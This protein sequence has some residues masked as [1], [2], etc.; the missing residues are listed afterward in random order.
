MQEEN[1]SHISSTSDHPIPASCRTL[2]DIVGWRALH[3]PDQQAYI[4]LDDGEKEAT[5]ITYAQLEWQAKSIAAQLQHATR[6]GERALLLYPPGLAYIAAFMGCLYAGVVAVPAYPPS[7]IRS[8]GRIQAIAADARA[9]LVLTTGQTIT[10]VARWSESMPELGAMRWLA[11]DEKLEGWYE[12]WQLQALTPETLTFLQYTSGSTGTPKG[13]MVSHGNL[14]HNCALMCERWGHSGAS[15]SVSWLPIF[16]DMGLIAG[17]LQPLYAGFLAVLMAPAA[18]IQRPVRWLQAISSYRGTTSWAPNFAYE[19]CVRRVTENECEQLDLRSWRVAGNGAEP[20]RAET[21][22]QFSRR[23]SVSGF[24]RAAFTPGYGLAEGTLMVASSPVEVAPVLLPLEKS[25]LELHR[26]VVGA[27]GPS[28]IQTFVGCGPGA[29]DQR[30]VIVNPETS[31]PCAPEEIGEI[32]VKGASITQGYWQRPQE[33]Q[34]IFMASLADTE[35]GPFLRTGDLGFLYHGELFITGRLKDIIIIRGRNHYPQD[36]ELTVEKSH[37]LLRPGCGAAFTVEVG[38]EE[39]LVIVQELMRDYHTIDEICQVIRQDVASL[40]EVQIYAIVLIRYGSISKT[41]SGKIQRRACRDA[42]VQ[43]NLQ[44][45]AQDVVM[46]EPLDNQVYKPL[47]S[48]AMLQAF[49]ADRQIALLQAGIQRH[50]EQI[51]HLKYEQIAFDIPMGAYGLDSLRAAELQMRLEDELDISLSFVDLLNGTTI[52]GLATIVLAQVGI[53]DVRTRQTAIIPDAQVPTTYPLSSWQEQLWVLYQLEPHS[54]FYTV[55]LALHMQGELNSMYLQR[56]LDEVVRRHESLRTTFRVTD[57][58]AVQSVHPY[59]VVQL[60]LVDLQGLS[61]GE[62][63]SREVQKKMGEMQQ[64]PFDLTQD[65]LLRVALF[66]LSPDESILL[67]VMHH[68]I[69]DG[70]SVGIFIRE[71]EQC[72]NAM[73]DNKDICLPALPLRYGDYVNWQRKMQQSAS[74]DE[75]RS[76]WKQQLEQVPV[77]DFPTDHPRPSVQRYRGAALRFSV[78]EVLVKRYQE[79]CSQEGVTLFMAFLAVFQLLLTR[80]SRQEECILGTVVANRP[81]LELKNLIG[82]F[83]NTLVIRTSVAKEQSYRQLLQVVR[84]VCLDAY[85]H[86]QFPFSRLVEELR[87]ERGLDRNPLFQ[88]VFNW[89]PDVLEELSFSGIQCVPYEIEEAT[90]RFDLSVEWMQRSTSLTATVIYNTDLFE[91]ATI[92]NLMTHYQVL[93]EACVTCPDDQIASMPLLSTAQY[94]HLVTSQKISDKP[95]G[96]VHELFAA[97][98]ERMPDALALVYG[99]ECLTYAE[100][101]RRS[102]NFATMLRLY[103]IEPGALVG[104]CLHRS[105]ELIVGLLG[106]LKA[107]GVYVPLDPAYPAQRLALMMHEAALQLVITRHGILSALPAIERVVL[108]LDDIEMQQRISLPQENRWSEERGLRMLYVIYTSGSTGQPKGAATYHHSFMALL[109]WFI[110]EF[111]ISSHDRVLLTSSFSFDLTQKNIFAP[112]LV[113]GTLVLH[114][115]QQFE[116]SLLS[117]SL[118]EQA[119]TVLNWTPS[120]FYSVIEHRSASAFP[121]LRSVFLGGEPVSGRRIISWLAEYP[122]EIINTYGPTE[123]TDVVAY[124]RSGIPA[125]LEMENVPIG[126]AIGGTRLLVLDEMQRLLPIGAIGE[127]CIAGTS[128]G[129]GY[130]NDAALTADRF[131]PDPF[132]DVPGQRLYQTGDH[133]RYRADGELEFIGR[134]DHQIKLHGY[135]IEL[136]EIEAVLHAHSA[137][138][139]CAVVLRED[140]AG[141]QRLVAYVVLYTAEGQMNMILSQLRRLMQEKLATYMLPSHIV[142]LEALPLTPSGKLDRRALPLPQRSNAESLETL[143]APRTLLEEILT[144]LWRDVL[145]VKEIGIHDNFFA[146]GGHSL[147]GAQLI[148]RIQA[149]LQVALSLRTVFEAPTI[150]E[151]AAWIQ[152]R[153]RDGATER[154]LPPLRATAECIPRPLSFAQERLWFL[155]QMF[156]GS[157]SYITPLPIRLH[158]NLEVQV[159]QRCWQEIVRRHQILRTSFREQD[160]QIVQ[161][162]ETLQETCWPCIDIRSLQAQRREILCAELIQQSMRSSFDLA[163]VPLWRIC[164]LRLS[165]QE[166]VLLI[167]IHHSIFDGWSQ[168]VL[169]NEL[170]VLYHAFS[171]DEPSP[172]PELPVQYSDFALWQRDWLQGNLLEDQLRYW[173]ERL[174]GCEPVKI[175]TDYPRPRVMSEQGAS[176]FFALSPQ[177]SQDLV[178]FSRSEEVTVFVTLLAAYKILLSRW[179]KQEDIVVGTDSANRTVAEVE[180]LIGFFINVL[181]LRTRCAGQLSFRRVLKLVR[182]MALEAFAHQDVPFEKIIDALGLERTPA[183]LPLVNI[184]FVWQNLPHVSTQNNGIEMTPQIVGVNATKFDLALFMWE[185]Q[186]RLRGAFNYSTA[187]LKDSTIS[188]LATRFERLLQSIIMYPDTAIEALDMY[189]EEEKQQI[190]STEEEMRKIQRRKIKAAKR[191]IIV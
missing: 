116:V 92:R 107:G 110:D 47:L 12:Q 32:W 79:L 133:V 186:G 34:H 81:R 45:I 27:K 80:Y 167:N 89:Q 172:L 6:P 103:G 84:A 67:I 14:M 155:A 185:E 177:L 137:V 37:P 182:A 162:V 55:P 174:R 128:V 180:P 170:S 39:R 11:T 191:N 164:L 22:E 97:Q 175:P 73:S 120:A 41:S 18:F 38:N 35:E 121:A 40:H 148:S 94:H 115:A 183:R 52:D 71:L 16:H 146:L 189:T 28:A 88:I 138:R 61:E 20:V 8:L 36:I 179:C 142:V 102:S 57:G 160:G 83:V 100:L 181:P 165:R 93:L 76:Y 70:W 187:L 95:S 106:I 176:Y 62:E 42:Y 178:S 44:I 72:Y 50:L 105:F 169:L 25:A 13:V 49:P 66:R 126:R 46:D 54:A 158:G 51:L 112:L 156:P 91:E 108:Y 168:S 21:I 7:S 99:D 1:V 64:R 145:A 127:L 184:L 15:V 161:Q 135:R 136:S 29:T 69:C 77:F 24:R 58:H 151:Q 59:A 123:C 117:Q 122:I 87:P 23:F 157:A 63:R 5:S 104:V 129:M 141:S 2:V 4:F 190:F 74:V 130:V 68:I 33:T 140:S 119:I 118:M 143:V 150:A 149:A 56:G 75:H 53:T 163:Q 114:P 26:V 153:I 159:L 134:V 65:T 86:Q 3:Q 125:R 82:F 113:G 101:D 124:F 188:L 85:A 48:R 131:M 60:L 10:K 166:H 152:A 139:Q 144:E 19:L 111:R 78:S 9:Q 96:L 98:A 31:L 30:I 154:R 171:N 90:S 173:I 109:R 43:G 132:S 147:S 17:V